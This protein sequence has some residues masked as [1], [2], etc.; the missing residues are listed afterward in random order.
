MMQAT[1][2]TR[3]W[4]TKCYSIEVYPVENGLCFPR[5]QCVGLLKRDPPLDTLSAA[6]G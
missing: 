4:L 6:K 5:L 1:P 2:D 3:P